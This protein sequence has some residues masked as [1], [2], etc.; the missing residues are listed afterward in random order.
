M[1]T[2]SEYARDCVVFGRPIGKDQGVGHL[3]AEAYLRLEGVKIATYHAASLYD[4]GGKESDITPVA[5]GVA[6]NNAKFLAAEA[7]FFACE[8]AVRTHWGYGVRG[9]VRH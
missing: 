4:K 1:S 6:C 7:A 5:V 3:L 2:A 8:L 9:R